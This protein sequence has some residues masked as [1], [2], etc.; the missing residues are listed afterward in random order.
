[1]PRRW[2]RLAR[3]VTAGLAG[4]G[5]LCVAHPLA[6][7]E[8]A[9][10]AI[11]AGRLVDVERGEVR[12]DQV[13]IVRGDRI[14][15]VQP[16]SAKLPAG[17]R[18][19][20]LSRWTVLPGLIDCHS[21]LV[22]EAT[23]ADVLQPLERSETQEA[24]SGVRNARATLL[25]GFTA[26]RDVGTYRAF[27]DAGLR[28]AIDD[29]TVIGPRMR[30]AGAYI[31]VSTGGGEL[32]GAAPDVTLPFAY[33]FGVANSADQVRERVRALLNGGADFIKIIATGAVLTRGTRPGVSEYTEEQIHAAVEQ[34]AEYGTFVAAHAHGAEGIK[35]AVRAG[36][37]SIEH[38]S[39]IDDEGIALMK[40]HGTWL[41]ADIWNGDYID[42][43][44]RAQHWPEEYLRKNTE[45]TEAQRAGFRKA[46][47][48]GVR[49]AYGTDS[50]VYPHG[51]NALQLPYMVKYGMTPMQAIQSATISAAQLMQWDD[52]I[53]SLAPGKF[54][55][56][57]A[58]E[59]DALADL[60]SFAKV[61]FVMKGGTVYKGP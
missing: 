14:T 55:D 11:R 20:D 50:G 18:V 60:R 43:V 30:V 52:R 41:V 26:V 46:V 32:V 24:M 10:T 6:A 34:A 57:V 9:L 21:H 44:G 15:A 45:T 4:G 22:G 13:V 54:A 48:A 3:V 47:A 12:R 28:D 7:Q 37:R 16:A 61:G 8:A 25:A 42:S 29:G 17:A 1:M 38:G 56:I 36:V 27:V 59:G 31:T 40:Q 39:L 51:L 19:I 35:R 23:A 2:S 58:V 49:I 53:G 5:L 33:R